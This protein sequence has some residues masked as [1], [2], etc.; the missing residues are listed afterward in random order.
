MH[1]TTIRRKSPLSVSVTIGSL[2]D[3]NQVVA[4]PALSFSETSTKSARCTGSVKT[5][6][7][8]RLDGSIDDSDDASWDETDANM[9][10]TRTLQKSSNFCS[11]VFKENRGS[12][13][14]RDFL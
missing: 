4:W 5:C 10:A 12:E 13:S 7:A 1:E 11:L 8:A 3:E 2:E 6:C 9:L 14:W